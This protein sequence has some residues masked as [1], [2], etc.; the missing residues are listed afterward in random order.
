[1]IYLKFLKRNLILYPVLGKPVYDIFSENSKG[2]NNNNIEKNIAA[3]DI[4]KNRTA[5]CNPWDPRGLC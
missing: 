2:K 5:K 1:M 4:S 3:T